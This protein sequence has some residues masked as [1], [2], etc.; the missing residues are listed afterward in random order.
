MLG[1]EAVE[2]I[3]KVPS[4][5]DTVHGHIMGMLVYTNNSVIGNLANTQFALQID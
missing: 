2:Q 1:P 5:N 3:S 4:S